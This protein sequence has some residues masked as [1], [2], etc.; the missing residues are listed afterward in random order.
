M[1]S[2]DLEKCRQ[3]FQ[4]LSGRQ[5]SEAEADELTKNC[6]SFREFR[7]KLI[8]SYGWLAELNRVAN[9][10]ADHV[11]AGVQ[12][13]DLN[14]LMHT[15]EALLERHDALE[16]KL[17]E[18]NESLLGKLMDMDRIATS[19]REINM[20][21]QEMRSL[22]STYRHRLAEVAQLPTI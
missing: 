9:R 7:V 2:N 20:Q 11:A 13:A 16:T 4:Y 21:L 10:W 15:M 22:I 12:S 6:P 1:T 3:L 17:K 19:Q 5:L 18:A 8:T 14:Q